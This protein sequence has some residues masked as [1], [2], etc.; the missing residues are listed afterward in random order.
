MDVEAWS[1]SDKGRDGSF[2]VFF[3]VDFSV[4]LASGLSGGPMIGTVEGIAWSSN[5]RAALEG[6]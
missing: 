2:D 1:T 4:P 5:N 6:G 3:G